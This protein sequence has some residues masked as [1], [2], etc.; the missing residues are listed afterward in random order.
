MTNTPG[1]KGS[2]GCWVRCDLDT[3][4]APTDTISA[5]SQVSYHHTPRS[6]SLILLMS[7]VNLRWWSAGDVNRL[8]VWQV[9]V[10]PFVCHTQE[11]PLIFWRGLAEYVAAS[12]N[13]PHRD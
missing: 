5:F 1:Q 9:F 12:P 8:T 3:L 6:A 10:V 11:I 7:V 2:R 13:D 4:L